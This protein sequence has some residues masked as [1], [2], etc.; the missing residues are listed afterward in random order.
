MS[1]M[2]VSAPAKSNM[3]T[4]FVAPH[5][6]ANIKGVSRRW[7]VRFTF[8][9]YWRSSLVISSLPCRAA[10]MSPVSPVVRLAALTGAP[11]F[12][13]VSRQGAW[14]ARTQIVNADSPSLSAMESD[15]PA[16]SKVRTASACPASAAAMSAVLPSKSAQSTEPPACS[17]KRATA[18]WP[19][20]DALCKAVCPLHTSYEVQL[21]PQFTNIRATSTC[22]PDAAII[23]AVTPSNA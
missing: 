12:N 13:M 22:P 3:W 17:S 21:A 4:T 7:F 18:E 2:V 5:P 19:R 16:H 20:A 8:A 10:A 1:W 9:W 11:A 23:S 14:P 15:A 6:P